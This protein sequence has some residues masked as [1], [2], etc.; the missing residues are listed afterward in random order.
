M[1]IWSIDNRR[2][3]SSAAICSG[4]WPGQ[5]AGLEDYAERIAR[6]ETVELRERSLVVH[7]EVVAAAIDR[8]K[9]K[10]GVHADRTRL[11]GRVDHRQPPAADVL[12]VK[13]AL[14]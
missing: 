13:L 2:V 6:Q 1:A 14:L 5:L 11:V 12:D 9:A 3:R 4:R 8:R 7:S 10:S